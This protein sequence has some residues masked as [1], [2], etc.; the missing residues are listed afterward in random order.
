V[1]ETND[2]PLAELEQIIGHQFR[3]REILRQAMRHGSAAAFSGDGSYQR[4]EFLGDAVL[5]H[6]LALLLYREF[7]DL[8]QGDLTRMRAHLARSSSLAEMA[9]LLGLDRFVELGPSEERARGRERYAL[10]EDVL[11][12][13]I[14]ALALDGGWEAAFDFVCAR[15]EPEFDHLDERTLTLANPKTALQEAAQAQGLPVPEYREH[16]V[17]GP[18]HQRM[19]VFHVSWDGEEIARGEGRSKRDAQQ[20]AA[21]RALIRLGLVPEE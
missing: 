8:D 19:W 2:D 9:A 4:L 10:L 11:E 6:A 3:D 16:G 15:F 18:D 7:P 1:N 5:G 20:Q 14:G 21:R 17:T 13:V 12:A